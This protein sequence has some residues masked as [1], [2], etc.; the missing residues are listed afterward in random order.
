MSGGYKNEDISYFLRTGAKT[1]DFICEL[2][3][4]QRGTHSLRRDTFQGWAQ[5]PSHFNISCGILGA[6]TYID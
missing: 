2:V 1:V 6:N 3:C 4:Y 5:R